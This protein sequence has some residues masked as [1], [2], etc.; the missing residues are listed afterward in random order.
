M[1]TKE[2]FQPD[3]RDAL[4]FDLAPILAFAPVLAL[5]AIVPVGPV[6]SNIFGT[7]GSGSRVALQIANPD[8]GLLYLFAI[9]SLA[10]YGTS[11]AG[12]A[13]NN[14]LALLGGV[15]ASSQMISYEVVARPLARRHD[16][17]LLQRPLRLDGDWLLGRR[18]SRVLG[19]VAI[20][21]LGLL[22]PAGRA[23][24]SSSRAAFAET[25]R[26]PFDLPEGE[27]E[28]VGY[29]VEYS[30]MKFGLFMILRVRRDRDARRRSPPPSSSA[31]GTRSSS[32][33]TLTRAG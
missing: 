1:L 17:G 13:S 28:I 15:R 7:G 20:P 31:A 9:A 22:P 27:S 23:S 11:L 2:D 29:F 18:A 3:E 12:W 26:A 30:G 10:V 6:A 24:S 21:A 14:K 16:D 19:K 32:S 5:F 8:V 33:E 4:L 25:K